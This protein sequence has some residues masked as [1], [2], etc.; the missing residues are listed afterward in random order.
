MAVDAIVLAAAICAG[1]PRLV[2]VLV[3][4]VTW[5]LGEAVGAKYGVP[6]AA[7]VAIG[8]AYLSSSR[9]PPPALVAGALLLALPRYAGATEAAL[10]AIAWATLAALLHQ[11]S[12]RFESGELPRW[13]RGAPARLFSAALLYTVALPVFTR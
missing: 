12:A 13:L 10:A 9:A 1:P 6:L 11:L 4:M 7:L 3:P 5:G 8:L 2:L